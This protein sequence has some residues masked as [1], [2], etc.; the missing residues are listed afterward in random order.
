MQAVFILTGGRYTFRPL[1]L[2]VDSWF[3]CQK[4]FVHVMPMWSFRNFSRL[5]FRLAILSILAVLLFALHIICLIAWSCITWIITITGSNSANFLILIPRFLARIVSTDDT[6]CRIFRIHGFTECI[7]LQFNSTNRSFISISDIDYTLSWIL[8][9]S[10]IARRRIV[11]QFWSTC[12]TS[13]IISALITT[14]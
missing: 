12:F 2:K 13:V 9:L 11:T 1:V 8:S 6:G 5:S 3:R 10:F 4:F 7:R 14:H